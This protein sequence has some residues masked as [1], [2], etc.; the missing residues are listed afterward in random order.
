MFQSIRTTMAA[1]STGLHSSRPREA[2]WQIEPEVSDPC[3]D[4]V[5]DALLV[6][7]SHK[8]PLRDETRAIFL[9]VTKTS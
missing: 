7:L 1:P 3:F 6:G 4:L 8:G 2:L 9:R 5:S